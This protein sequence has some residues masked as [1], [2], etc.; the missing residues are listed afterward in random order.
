MNI[1]LVEFHDYEDSRMD[2]AWLEEAKAATRADALNHE[3]F[4]ASRPSYEAEA[5]RYREMALSEEEI[6][7]L[8]A[9]AISSMARE[10]GVR[11]AARAIVEA[12]KSANGNLHEG[13]PRVAAEANAA[14]A[15]YEG[16]SEHRALWN[17]GA[18]RLEDAPEGEA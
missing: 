9:Y 4:E 5:K 7:Y 14:M 6:A 8:D 12:F 11:R 17:I 18:L 10:R 15:T 3:E 2:S 16:W 1:Y 13:D